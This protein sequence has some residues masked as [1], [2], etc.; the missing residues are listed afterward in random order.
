M[1]LSAPRETNMRA[2]HTKMFFIILFLSFLV[3]KPS[4]EISKKLLKECQ[5]DH[6]SFETI[7]SLLE[8]KA[9]PNINNQ[10]TPLHAI[11]RNH[12]H[13]RYVIHVMDLLLVHKADPT[14]KD[15]NSY[16]PLH[17]WARENG[18]IQGIVCL[19]KG[20]FE[21]P[22]S[23]SIDQLLQMHDHKKVALRYL[24]CLK[25]KK[26][27]LPKYINFEI[28]KKAARETVPTKI[29]QFVTTTID[30]NSDKFNEYTAAQILTEH[31]GEK[32]DGG[33]KFW[34]NRELLW[35][36]ELLKWKSHEEVMHC[37]NGSSL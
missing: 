9:N 21:I 5:K 7:N 12:L 16:T 14:I 19:I 8:E 13:K 22:N 36:L 33:D 31:F 27:K 11:A 18:R 1:R 34:K 28:L 26:L 17:M 29:K 3:V 23:I 15:S 25:S 4:E 35:K 10:E 24:C 37:I 20:A 2:T 30:N 32:I 6:F